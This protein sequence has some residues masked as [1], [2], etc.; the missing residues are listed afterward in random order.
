[1][2][3]PFVSMSETPAPSNG[4]PVAG[5]ITPTPNPAAEGLL[6]QAD[7]MAEKLAE[8]Q[9]QLKALESRLAEEEKQRK[10]KEALLAVHAENYRKLQLP[11]AEAVIKHLEEKM[12]AE[13]RTLDEKTKEMYR[14]T[15]ANPQHEQHAER[16]FTEFQHD[17]K[18]AAS[19]K[20]QDEKM[21]A[22]EAE[23]KRLQE[24]LNKA[25]QTLSA[26][27]SSRATYVDALAAANPG[28]ETVNVAASAGGRPALP[29][30]HVMTALPH[31]AEL[32]FLKEAGVSGT[33]SITASN[34]LTGEP[35]L[36]AMQTSVLA[37][38]GHGLLINPDT[39]NENF[40]NSMR[41]V[42]PA[43]F[44]WLMN[45]SGL[46][47]ANVDHLTHVTDSKLFPNQEQRVDGGFAGITAAPI[48]K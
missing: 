46:V 37:A 14:N 21:A 9:K 47:D 30:G 13:G 45:S 16:M 28:P 31:A 40:P 44:G 17:V 7:S 10:E 5:S 41:N 39:K 32:P 42:H 48:A 19:R 4:A 15:F 23:Q 18:V 25:T 8:S 3:V 24:A 2:F 27:L 6:R 43:L 20:A 36:R 35:E 11:K 33:F 34:A 12:A 38:R 1:M 26:G 29:P 22:L